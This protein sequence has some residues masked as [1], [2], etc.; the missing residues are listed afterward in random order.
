MDKPL[1]IR[2]YQLMCI[3][4]KS[5]GG[6]SKT[7]VDRK[8]KEILGKIKQ[9]PDRP[10]T[11]VCNVSNIYSYQNPGIADDTPEGILFN[12]KRDLDILRLMGLVPG[13]TMPARAL[14]EKIIR[15]ITTSREICGGNSNSRIW[16]GCKKATS[17]DYEKARKKGLGLVIPERSDIEMKKAKEISVKKMY[18]SKMLYIRPSHLMCMACFSAGPNAGA[19]IPEDNLYEAIDI[20]RKNPDIPIKLVEGPCMI[21]QPC[22]EFVPQK[23]IC[24]GGNSMSLRDELK[25]LMIL[26]KLDIEYGMIFPARELFRMLFTKIK[27]TR[28][29]CGFGDGIKSSPEWTSGC[30]SSLSMK[31]SPEYKKARE[32]GMRIPGLKIKK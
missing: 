6:F 15:Y 22:K 19:P 20:V 27:S 29:I 12:K 31:G 16:K 8:L 2:P 14:L 11:L 32:E 10:L 30:H 13:T 7:A 3:L 1:K 9:N 4:C 23:N 28:D 5:E 25:D 26:Q 21:C 18:R 17:G 24:T